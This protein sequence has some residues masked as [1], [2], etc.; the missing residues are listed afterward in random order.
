MRKLMW[1]A[2][3]FGAACGLC[4]YLW[5]IPGA[6][7]IAAVL[8]AAFAVLLFA[9]WRAKWLKKA[10]AVCLGCVAGLAWFEVYSAAY[11]DTAIAMDGVTAEISAQCSD[12]GY[13]TNYGTAVD[14]IVYLDGKPYRARFYVNGDIDFEPGDVLQGT[15]RFRLT[16]P[17]G[18]EDATYH[19]GK[20]IFLLAYQTEDAALAKASKIPWY[21]YPAKLRRQ[22]INLINDCFPEDTVAFARAL[23]LGDRSGIDYETSTAFKVSGISH[24]IA[25]S[26]LHVSILFTLIYTLGFKRRIPTAVVGITALT[27]FAAVAGFSP[28]VT[29]A[30]IMQILMILAMLFD[31]E[32]DGPTELAFSA[33]VM[34]IAN[35]L[36]IT[37]VSFQLS[38]GC[39]AG[40]FLFRG[41][42]AAWMTEKLGCGKKARFVKQKR[43]LAGSVAVT[44]SAMSLTTPLV[45]YYFGAVSLVGVL[46]N[47]LTLWAVTFIFYG[48]M[49]V[50]LMGALAPAVGAFLAGVISWPVRYVL[51]A[52]K[53][54]AKFPLAAVYTRSV[55]IVAWLVFIYVLLAVFLL[56]KTKRPG[57]LFCCGMLGL[58]LVLAASWAEPMTDACRMTVLDVGQGQSIILQSEGKTYLVDC[59]GSY[60][61]DAADLAAETL[62]SQ[63][64]FHLDGIILTHYDRDHAGGLPYLFTRM[65]ADT[66]FLP[67]AEDENG[68]GAVLEELTQGS[69]IYVSDDLSLTYGG[70]ELTIFGPALTDS[71]NESSLAVLFQAENCDILITGDRSDFG[72]RMLLRQTELPQLEILVAGH[73]GSKSSTCTELLEATRPAIVAISVGE[74]SYGHPAQ[75][76]LDRL[77]AYGCLVYRTDRDGNLIFRR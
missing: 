21:F 71:S 8:T 6:F 58:C 19:Q 34:L 47:L 31:K 48:I 54:L 50:C 49:L 61:E 45:A 52:A 13:E 1:F 3:G 16:T 41:K 14:G 2:L 77:A 10:A 29:R 67:A 57:T 35:P 65:P 36:V 40:I 44:L 4:A 7:W 62:M 11:L 24:I 55:Y 26:G 20:G 33:L 27:L 37:S 28:S 43:W 51:A 32:Y 75:E 30:C 64:I 69:I 15:F 46:T 9:G 5:E 42:I 59:G 22:L 76:L 60:D 39:I 70:T 63:G 18:E 56:S 72:E 38:V 12:Y 68:V 74:N 66:L 23:L 73:H 17:G 25:V 53:I